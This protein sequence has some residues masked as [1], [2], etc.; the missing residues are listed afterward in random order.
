[1]SEPSGLL[2]AD[3]IAAIRERASKATPGPWT[4]DCEDADCAIWG[5]KGD[6]LGDVGN[7]ARQTGN[8]PAQ[9]TPERMAAA[10][11]QFAEF[12]DRADT[13]FV[14]HARED[15]PRLIATVDAQAAQLARVESLLRR[16]YA[17]LPMA[18]TRSE[19]QS[20]DLYSL[21]GEIMAALAQRAGEA[22]GESEMMRDLPEWATDR[23]F[24][25]TDVYL[26]W[27]DR[28]RVLRDGQFTIS[29]ETDVEHKPGRAQTVSRV[30]FYRWRWPWV[31]HMQLGYAETNPPEPDHD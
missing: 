25:H 26:S 11:Q 7:W 29:T 23:I 6:Y 3:E 15:I 10:C 18:N 9:M 12:A 17:W 21:S 24:V 30:H 4:W 2:S 8:D 14:A 20:D 28:L 13:E 31:K 1:M 19:A 27:Q 16:A 5:P 22:G